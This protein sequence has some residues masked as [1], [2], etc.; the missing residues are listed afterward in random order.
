MS[1]KKH[2][3]SEPESFLD[4]RLSR[5]KAIQAAREAVR[6]T[7]RLTRLIS[8]LNDPGPLSVILD[9]G[10][11]TLSELFLSDI[12]VL[13]DPVGTGSFSPLAAIGLP[14]DMIEQP[15]S[16]DEGGYVRQLMSDGVPL[17]SNC[18]Q[19][20]KAIDSQLI[21]LGAEAVAGLPV[22]DNY[23]LRGALILARCHIEPFSEDDIGLLKTMSYRIGRTLIES[24]R[25]FQFEKI[26][27]SSA[28]INRYLD[29][30]A[31]I[32]EA[33]KMFPVIIRGQGAALVMKEEGGVFHCAGQ[34]GL[35]ARCCQS[36]VD[37]SKDLITNTVLA[38]A[39]TLNIEDVS[40]SGVLSL[41]A[42]LQLL[43]R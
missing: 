5:D 2:S 18:A 11:A 12:V 19:T 32:S 22:Y 42:L 36:L 41:T 10:L 34:W 6:D 4:L 23:G 31:V 30:N 14:E 9:R 21:E 13:L 17:R 35:N 8:I 15:F 29:F 33:V 25:S 26:V 28:K 38:K 37:I 16:S 7:T 39:E 20:D 1:A 40:A 43:R 3:L 27:E 24:Q